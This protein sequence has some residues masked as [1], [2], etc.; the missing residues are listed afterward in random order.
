MKHKAEFLKYLDK[1]LSEEEMKSVEELLRND[2]EQR[3]IFETIKAK[4][5]KTLNL[6]DSLNP[7][8]E[9]AIPSFK[10]NKQP[11][12]NKAKKHLFLRPIFWR[13]A[14]LILVLTTFIFGF[15]FIQHQTT[16]PQLTENIE[17]IKAEDQ[18]NGFD[19]LNYY[20]S[21]NRSWNERELVWTV[22]EIK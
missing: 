3:K 4:R 18:T 13:Y 20:I 16:N 21:P 19:E 17:T 8:D 5:N 14:A 15:W 7:Q 1:E 12:Q 9:I 11:L 10:I 2:Q 22:V 6:L